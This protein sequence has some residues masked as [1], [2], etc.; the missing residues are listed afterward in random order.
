MEAIQKDANKKRIIVT[1]EVSTEG[2]F[3]NCTR[4]IGTRK[5]HRSYFH[6]T[7]LAVYQVALGTFIP[8]PRSLE[9]IVPDHE[10]RNSMDNRVANL[11]WLTLQLNQLNKDAMFDENNQLKSGVGVEVYKT[12]RRGKRYRARISY[13]SEKIHLGT[14]GTM[15]EADDAYRRA[16]RDM[17]EIMM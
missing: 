4:K 6:W 2:R 17:F 8:Q 3:R 11:R 9:V 14:Y 7:N 16:W 10:N 15:A 12:K 13:H 5:D 1:G